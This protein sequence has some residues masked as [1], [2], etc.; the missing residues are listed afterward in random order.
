MASEAPRAPRRDAL[1]AAGLAV[2]A[3]AVLI[4]YLLVELAATGGS[5]EFPLDDTY[6]H[7]QFAR[8]LAAGRGLSYNPGEL[9]TGSTA[10]LW[11]ALLSL[12]FLLPGDVFA[13]VKVLGCA[14]HLAGLDATRRLAVELGL[15]RGLAWLAAAVALATS[16]LSWSALSGMEIP[17]FIVLSL[18]GMVLH[19]RERGS[20]GRPP[21]SLAVLGISILARPEGALLFLLALFDRLLH[22]SRDDATRA[23]VWHFPG[24]REGRALLWGAAV[25]LVALAGPLLFYAWAGGS[26]LPTTYAAKAGSAGPNL[27]GLAYL[28][29]VWG[30][31]FRAQP[32]PALLAGSGALVLLERLGTRGDRGLLPL[33]WLAG[34]PL[35]Y[36]LITPQS[37]RLLGNFGRYFFP[38]LPVVAVLA[39]L[40]VERAARALSAPLSVGRLRVRLDLAL[41]GLVLLPAAWGV[42]DGARLYG[43]NVANV[44]QSNVALARWLAPRLSAQA[45]LAVND[46]GALKFLLPNRIVDVKSIATPAWREEVRRDSFS[47]LSHDRAVLA[48]LARRRP[49]YVIVFPSWLPAVGRNPRFRPVHRLAIPGNVTMGSD[50]IVV[51]ATPW[52]R[53]PLSP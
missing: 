19:A 42:V 2:L 41:A 40:G 45:V 28:S 26:I 30:V 33:L 32:L 7:L 16:W 9:V 1:F 47:G 34:L 52:T 17:L 5:L 39:L 43:R 36:S 20:P 15:S 44:H 29:S 3:A 37:T 22:C 24:S 27:P 48:A 8:N 35:A 14:L 51:Y 53:F 31:L 25:A 6:I 21:L 10:P 12:L 46:I 50:E 13:W 38:L 11:T 4:A 23:L 49:D 18:W